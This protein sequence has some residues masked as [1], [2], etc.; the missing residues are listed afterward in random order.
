M[1]VAA[2][3]TLLYFYDIRI[4]GEGDPKMWIK[5]EDVNQ[6]NNLADVIHIRIAPK[7]EGALAALG[8]IRIM[9]PR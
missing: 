6:S 5:R 7:G 4:E 3:R 2:L 1:S 9:P 8:S